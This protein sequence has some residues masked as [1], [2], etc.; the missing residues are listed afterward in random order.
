MSKT[1]IKSPD[2]QYKRAM[3]YRKFINS[4]EDDFTKL[5]S[6]AARK[7][8]GTILFGDL[9]IN[10]FERP[11]VDDEALFAIDLK[12]RPVRKLVGMRYFI[13]PTF[14]IFGHYGRKKNG[15]PAA[16]GTY[17]LNKNHRRSDEFFWNCLDGMLFRPELIPLYEQGEPLE[18]ITEIRDGTGKV[19]HDFFDFTTMKINKDKYSD[20]LPIKFTFKL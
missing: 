5:P 1:N 12:K 6:G 13:N 8:E 16:P 17:Y 4:T 15:Q 9:N 2:D 14:S 7:V 19:K 11:L 3:E 10:P 20:H 18:I